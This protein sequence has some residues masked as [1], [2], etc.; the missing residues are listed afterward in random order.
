MQVQVD[1][2]CQVLT[3]L[4]TLVELS[5]A[6]TPLNTSVS[7]AQ[8]NLN[9]FHTTQVFLVITLNAKFRDIVA[10][11]IIIVLLDISRR[12][13]SNV[14][15]HMGSY[16][17]LILAHRSFLGIETR[18]AEHLLLEN[19]IV[20]I[21][22]L[23]HKELLRIAR[24][25]RVLIAVF[26]RCHTHIELFLGDTQGLTEL[27]RVKSV[28]CLVHHHHDVIRRLIKHHQLPMAIHDVTTRGVFD[29]LQ[30]GIRV[31]TLFIVGTGNLECKQTDDID[32]HNQ[33]GH[34]CY[35]VMPVFKLR[36]PH[37]ERTLSIAKIINSVSRALPS[38][39]KPHNC[40]SKNENAS[41]AK[42]KKQ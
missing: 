15:Q 4:S 28:A 19:A 16:R 11:L 24:I 14:T 27:H 18:K 21:G 33:Y 37:F 10:R 38:A 32:D 20:L 29:F 35:H 8:K 13:L 1:T 9:T 31:G 23:T 36:F 30:E 34:P 2:Q 41:R 7:I 39:R 6:I 40:Q 25:T 5:I 42:N 26:H 3:W 22:E 17:I 12:H